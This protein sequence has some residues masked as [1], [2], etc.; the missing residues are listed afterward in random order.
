M[1]KIKEV[2]EVDKLE[3]ARKILLD[4][5]KKK[6]QEFLKEYQELC[7]KHKMELVPVAGINI[8]IIN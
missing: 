5:Q 2:E 8:Q 1:E 7:Q 4:E 6:Q 3:E